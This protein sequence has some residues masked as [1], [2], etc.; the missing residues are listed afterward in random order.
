MFSQQHMPFVAAAAQIDAEAEIK[1][2]I[3]ASGVAIA[4]A[5]CL[6]VPSSADAA[7]GTFFKARSTRLEQDAQVMPPIDRFRELMEVVSGIVGKRLNLSTMA[8]SSQAV[9]S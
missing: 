8:R 9:F 7:P 6:F 3:I 1:N 5:A 4:L 2:R